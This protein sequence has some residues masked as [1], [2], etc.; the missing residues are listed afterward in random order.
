MTWHVDTAVLRQYRSDQ[1]SEAHMASVELHVTACA[2]C[3][4]LV[5]AEADGATRAA[6]ERVKQVVED[7][8]D[9]APVA[10]F[11]RALGRMGVNDRDAGILAATL[12]LHGSWVG[13]FGLAMAFVVLAAWTGPAG[14]GLATFLV[15]APL[16]PLAG[17]ALAYGPRVDPTYEIA[18]A[19]SVPAARVILLRTLAVT[20]PALPVIVALSFLLPG[21]ALTFAWLL[22]ALGLA[23]ASL[24]LGT[25]VP[26]NRAAAGLAGAWV[27]GA[28]ASVTL[29]PRLGAEA[30]VRS[31]AAFR[32]SG[33]LLCAA[34]AALS[35]VL[36]ALRRSD[37]E[38]AR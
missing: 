35:V 15:A 13:A 7:K 24:A 11:Q 31:F 38:T 20:A 37:F 33:Q 30:F 2:P 28:A 29:A 14:A 25:L 3:R 23:T 6:Q 16:I 34:V 1:L 5:A 22:P 12:S 19:A 27:T 32:P 8:L 4:S 9:V 10:W 17:V 26:L 21:G 18:L 36:V